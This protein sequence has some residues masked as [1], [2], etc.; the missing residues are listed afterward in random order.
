MCFAGGPGQIVEVGGPALIRKAAET[1]AVELL[2]ERRPF[3][4]GQLIERTVIAADTQ[5][6]RELGLPGV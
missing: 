5:R 1:T 3:F 2:R 6:L 4:N